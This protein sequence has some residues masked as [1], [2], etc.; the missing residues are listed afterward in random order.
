[1]NDAEEHYYLRRLAMSV[2]DE[3]IGGAE[4]TGDRS[5][6]VLRYSD[7]LRGLIAPEGVLAIYC[8][9]FSK[10]G[11]SLGQWRAYGDDGKGVAIG[12]DRAYFQDLEGPRLKVV[13]IEYDEK[14]HRRIVQE[15][16]GPSL[17]KIDSAPPKSKQFGEARSEVL[18]RIDE[19]KL[20]KLAARCKNP[21]FREEQETRVILYDAGEEGPKGVG[22]A[23]FR[24]SGDF[25]V[26]YY[27]LQIDPA[28]VPCPIQE[29]VYGPKN[30]DSLNRLFAFEILKVFG[31]RAE[32]IEGVKSKASYR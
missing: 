12:F 29:I 15:I 21:T 25:L 3:A 10:D 14:E 9:C 31:F 8:A 27:P 13:D 1:M 17:A 23:K 4:G 28:V 5:E 7:S 19:F 2:I 30:P 26:K 16:I 11:D 22:P 32:R 24:V 6:F 20:W 18:A